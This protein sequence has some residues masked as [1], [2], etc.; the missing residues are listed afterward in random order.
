MSAVRRASLW[1]R[2]WDLPANQLH[3][4]HSCTRGPL[5]FSCQQMAVWYFAEHRHQQLLRKHTELYQV[6]L[7]ED[8]RELSPVD[9]EAAT[10]LPLSVLSEVIVPSSRL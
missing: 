1:V 3:G 9:L 4:E 6:R 7:V 5:V 10:W 8:L 2:R